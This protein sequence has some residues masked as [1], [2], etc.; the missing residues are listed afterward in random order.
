[1]NRSSTKLRSDHTSRRVCSEV[2]FTDSTAAVGVWVKACR[3]RR[4]GECTC[5]SWVFD[6][7]VSMWACMCWSCMCKY[8]KVVCMCACRCVRSTY[9]AMCIIRFSTL[10]TF[11]WKAKK[12]WARC[13]LS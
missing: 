10:M 2:Y 5:V 8:V 12:E 13:V 4:V 3:W 11:C 9:E 6:L 7:G 1:M